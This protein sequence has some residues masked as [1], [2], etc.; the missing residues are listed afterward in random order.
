MHTANRKRK[1]HYVTRHCQYHT[2]YSVDGMQERLNTIG[3]IGARLA[4]E[5]SGSRDKL[6]EDCT[7]QN[8]H[9]AYYYYYYYY[10]Y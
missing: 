2:P 6:L 1:G 7:S 9:K 5:N 3:E 10:Y 8:G 4:Q